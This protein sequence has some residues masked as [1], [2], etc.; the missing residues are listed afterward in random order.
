MR[1]YYIFN[2]LPLFLAGIYKRVISICKAN[3][4][5]NNNILL[6]T[7]T[8]NKMWVKGRKVYMQRFLG[9]TY[10]WY[11]GHILLQDSSGHLLNLAKFEDK[12]CGSQR[13]RMTFLQNSQRCLIQ[14]SQRCLIYRHLIN[15]RPDNRKLPTKLYIEHKNSQAITWLF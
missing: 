1:S 3:K 8:N 7:C 6:F 9:N 10:L 14:N 2:I 13:C 11:G 5:C 12:P 15:H 4:K